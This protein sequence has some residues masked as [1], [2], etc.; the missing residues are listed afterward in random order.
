VAGRELVA[1][2]VAVRAAVAEHR[3]VGVLPGEEPAVA[4]RQ[5]HRVTDVALRQLL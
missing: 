3:V 5:R 2:G 1:A 4:W